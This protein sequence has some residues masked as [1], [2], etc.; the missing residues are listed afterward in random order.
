MYKASNISERNSLQRNLLQCLYKDRVRPIG[1]KSGNLAWTLAYFSG[2]HRFFAAD[3]SH[4]ARQN[5]AVL[6]GSPIETYSRISWSLVQGSRDTMQRYASVLHSYTCKVVFSTTSPCVPVVLMLFLFT[7]TLE[8]YVKVF[9]IS[10]RHRAVF[11]A[12][13]RPSCQ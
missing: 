13:A 5:L 7:S 12:T 2:E 3:I 11:P 1:D 10:A 9:G 8:N 6:G 4:R